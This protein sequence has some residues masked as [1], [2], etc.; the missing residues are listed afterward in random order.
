MFQSDTSELASD[1]VFRQ[2]YARRKQIFSSDLVT[3]QK[4]FD[5][6]NVPNLMPRVPRALTERGGIILLL[7]LQEF[8]RTE[9]DTLSGGKKRPDGATGSF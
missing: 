3:I 8:L 2:S 4:V 1:E 6:S 9:A 7:E 5:C